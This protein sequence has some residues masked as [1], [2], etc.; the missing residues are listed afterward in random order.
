MEG[1]C[2]YFS[3]YWCQALESHKKRNVQGR[4]RFLTYFYLFA[5]AC[6]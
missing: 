5:Q 6:I 2:H 1:G 3:T 4:R